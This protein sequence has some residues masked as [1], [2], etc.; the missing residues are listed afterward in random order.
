MSKSEDKSDKSFLQTVPGIIAAFAALITAIGGCIAVV[1]GIPAIS[2]AVFGGTPTPIISQTTSSPIIDIPT[3]TFDPTKVALESQ[4]TAVSLQLA[5]S[6]AV[7]ATTISLQS[8]Q[9]AAAQATTTSL[10]LTQSAAAQATTA[11][12]QLTQSAAAQAPIQQV[13]PADGYYNVSPK[14]SNKCLGIG[15]GSLDNGAGVIQWDCDG[16]PDQMWH[17]TPKGDGY[18]NVSPKSSNKCLGIGNGSLDNGAGVIQ[19]DCDGL[20]DQLWKLIPTSDGYY[21]VSPKSSNKCLGIGNGSL[22]NGVGVIQWDCDGLPDQLW[23]LT[24]VP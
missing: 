2:N 16:L 19:W 20:P 10:Q 3:L 18:Y 11:S 7:Q 22:D 21:N 8:T 5:Q 15:N 4:A 12:L 23:K 9:S 6:T 13:M 14:S 24:L 1:F 17:F